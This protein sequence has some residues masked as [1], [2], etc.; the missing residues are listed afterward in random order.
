MKIQIMRKTA[1]MWEYKVDI[2]PIIANILVFRLEPDSVRS[3]NIV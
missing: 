1:A 3:G 2:N